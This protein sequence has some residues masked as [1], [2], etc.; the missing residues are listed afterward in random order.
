MKEIIDEKTILKM[1][2]NEEI[3]NY[4]RKAFP[5]LW[6]KLYCES[7]SSFLEDN[8]VDYACIS[9]RL[10]SVRTTILIM[11]KI[12]EVINKNFS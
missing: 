1:A 9:D 5:S 12:Q 6:H 8:S 4:Y 2:K 3:Q 7:V 10:F 11:K